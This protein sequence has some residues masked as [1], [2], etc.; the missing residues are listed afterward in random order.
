MQVRAFVAI[1]GS[2][3]P[4]KF[5]NRSTIQNKGNKRV[6]QLAQK[7]ILIVVSAKTL[8]ASANTT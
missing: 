3:K 7:K 8:T 6:K 2:G 5:M 4:Q 1:E